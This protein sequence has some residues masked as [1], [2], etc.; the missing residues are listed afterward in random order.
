MCCAA[1]RKISCVGKYVVRSGKY[2]VLLENMSCDV[3][4]LVTKKILYGRVKL[5]SYLRFA[6]EQTLIKIV[7]SCMLK[8]MISKAANLTKFY[9][10]TSS[11]FCR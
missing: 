1:N 8:E 9:K 4:N 11:N 7:I 5:F 3:E 2:V 6:K 10:F